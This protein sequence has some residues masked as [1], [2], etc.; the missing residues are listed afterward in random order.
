VIK[1]EGT[2][3]SPTPAV[4]VWTI[5]ALLNWTEKFFAQKRVDSPRLDAQVLLAHALGCKRID[6]YARSTEEAPETERTQ[7]RDLV[8][9]RVEGC[10]VAYLVGTKEFYLLSFEVTPAVLIPRPATEALVLAALD[11][12]KPLAAPR[13]IDVGTGSGCIAVNVAKQHSGASLV[14]TDVSGEALAV[15]S[16]NAERHGVV[17][18]VTFLQ[19]DL[20]ARLGH[21]PP[22]D[23]I[24][25]NPPYIRTAD[26]AG[27][28]ADVR[29]HEPRQALD[30]GPDGFAVID[31]LLAEAPAHL[32]PGGSLL[33]EIGSDQGD[34]MLCRLRATPGLADEHI[35]PDRD[36][37]ARVAVA[38][39]E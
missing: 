17:N 31:R 25:S 13:V 6:L 33:I 28:A 1:L 35:L 23:L 37:H 3:N 10:P 19:S 29:D 36:G 18:R 7:F 26:L 30:G 14:A 27:L 15:A 34:D 5:G 20:F 21:E 8:R 38:R 4:E 16:R 12:L 39:R 2:M 9:R 11:R 32:R 24:L 22:F